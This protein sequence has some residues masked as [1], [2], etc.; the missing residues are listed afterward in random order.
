MIHADGQNLPNLPAFGQDRDCSDFGILCA[1]CR[2][3]AARC[4]KQPQSCRQNG[5]DD[6]PQKSH[7]SVSTIML[8]A[9]AQLPASCRLWAELPLLSFHCRP[10]KRLQWPRPIAESSFGQLGVEFSAPHNP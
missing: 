5:K 2:V 3:A 10:S 9:F 1:I 7:P 6:Q 4:D 8:W